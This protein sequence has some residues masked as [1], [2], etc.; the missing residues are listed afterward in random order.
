LLD[1]AM[2]SRIFD[3][4]SAV[5]VHHERWNRSAVPQKVPRRKVD[6]NEHF[7]IWLHT[8]SPLSGK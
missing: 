7:W 8:D 5:L 6:M 4:R 1:F 3:M 2:Q